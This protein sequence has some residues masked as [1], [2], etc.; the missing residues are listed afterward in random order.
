MGVRRLPRVATAA[1][2]LPTFSDLLEIGSHTLSHPTLSA[3]AASE[4]REEIATSKRVLEDQLGREVHSF[5][6]PFGARGTFDDAAVRDVDD[7]GYA[8]AFT[9]VSGSFR[10]G[11]DALRIPRR[12]VGNW[13]GAELERRLGRWLA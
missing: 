13:S 1:E 6:Y 12:V 8:C 10:A 9:N 11:S 7:A 2:I 5:A 4:R 3:I